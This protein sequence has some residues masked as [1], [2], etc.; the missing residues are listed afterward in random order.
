MTEQNFE[1]SR[2]ELDQQQSR[3][4]VQEQGGTQESEP[5]WSPMS[6]P[7][8][9]QPPDRP[10]RGRPPGSRNK[11]KDGAAVGQVPQTSFE[12]E[13][14][15]DEELVTHLQEA[16]DEYEQKVELAESEFAKPYV[17]AHKALPRLRKSIA[18]MIPKDGQEHRYRVYGWV[19]KVG[20]PTD[21]KEVAFT[22]RGKQSVAIERADEP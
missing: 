14:L 18:D 21:D 12:D 16:L 20:P 1:T 4:A 10:R 8:E 19:L 17:D 15:S 7:S 13:Y 11:P 9:P 22:R 2:E 3:Q 5:E 6:N